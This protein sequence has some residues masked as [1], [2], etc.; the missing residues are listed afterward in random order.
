[1]SNASALLSVL[2]RQSDTIQILFEHLFKIFR[3]S[4]LLCV[5]VTSTSKM[6]MVTISRKAESEMELVCSLS[7]RQFTRFQVLPIHP[8][9]IE[10]TSMYLKATNKSYNEND[11]AVSSDDTRG[12]LHTDRH[13]G[14]LFL[15]L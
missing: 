11:L 3:R 8:L 13:V 2:V 14:L 4:V 10:W 15:W 1:M 5:T 7:R 9:T 12:S 6:S